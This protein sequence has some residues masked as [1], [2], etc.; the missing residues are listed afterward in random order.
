M[1]GVGEMKKV[2]GMIQLFRVELPLAA[3]ICTVL[4]ELFAL[5]ALPSAGALILGFLSVFCISAAALILN[6]YF[7]V[8]VDRINVPDRPLPA[9]LVTRRDV[10]LLSIV[11]MIVGFAAAALISIEALLVS[12][13]VWALGFLYNWRYKRAGLVGNLLVS[14][15][16]GMTFIYGGLA[17]GR[18]F[19]V[20][21]WY[22]AGL[23]MLIDLG[24]E[25]TGDAMDMVG[26]TEI[27]SRSLAL[28]L[29]R[30]AALRISR[31]IFLGVVLYSSLPFLAGW[32]EPKYIWPV[33]FMDGV[34]L[35]STWKL[36][37]PRTE[38]PRRYMRWIYLSGTLAMVVMLVIRLVS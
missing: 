24:E 11:V 21:V 38:A 4:G 28:S 25:I 18:P 7:D 35:Y 32:L 36:V 9:G 30:D 13:L 1:S 14:I 29:G 5:G 37:D 27:D 34:I 31:V 12:V 20:I 19:E 2:K 26:D 15:S 3:G 33:V 8:A 6:D 16:V 22:F 10:L 17:V 23:A